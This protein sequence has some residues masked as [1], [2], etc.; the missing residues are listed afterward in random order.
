M[1]K[2]K[3]GEDWS[4]TMMKET[5]VAEYKNLTLYSSL[6]KMGTKGL[7]SNENKF[8]PPDEYRTA[9]MKVSEKKDK[10]ELRDFKKLI[11]ELTRK[12]NPE[13]AKRL[14]VKC[15]GEFE[16]QLENIGVAFGL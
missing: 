13:A 5:E 10:V 2:Q 16:Q 12:S 9:F 3:M 7:Q 15:S 1:K 6:K 14:T 8:F 4:I 11:E